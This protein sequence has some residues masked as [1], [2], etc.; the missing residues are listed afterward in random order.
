[1][2]SHEQVLQVLA[3]PLVTEPLGLRDRAYL[4]MAYG[5]EMRRGE[6]HALE[7]TD[8]D[9]NQGLVLVRKPKNMEQRTVPLTNWALHYLLRYLEEARPKLTS[10]LSLN[11]LWLSET[12]RRMRLSGL[13]ERFYKEYR[14]HKTL[15]FPFTLHQMR[16]ACATHLLQAGAS[17]REIQQLLGHRELASTEIYT[18]LTPTRLR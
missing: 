4:E 14:A 18:H 3:I 10:P 6:L 15:D 16:H 7:L 2:L 8:L 13:G 9:L 5:T 12:G 1:M 17:I 11:A